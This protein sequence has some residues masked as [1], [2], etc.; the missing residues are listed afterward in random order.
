M[1]KILLILILFFTLHSNVILFAGFGNS[2]KVGNFFQYTID[3]FPF[4]D[5]YAN[6]E[7]ISDTTLNNGITYS[8]IKKYYIGG[9]NY[10]Y[11]EYID[12]VTN[13]WYVYDPTCLSADTNGNFLK[14][15]LNSDSGDIWNGCGYDILV[16]N[17]GMIGN[18][19][20]KQNL[21][22]VTL[23]AYPIITDGQFDTYID[24][25]GYKGTNGYNFQSELTGAI[26]DGV[27]Y[28]NIV[29]INQISTQVPEKFNLYNNYPNPF[30]PTTRIKFEIPKNVKVSLKVFDILGRE[31][32][33]LVNSELN[34]GVYEYTFE[35]ARLSSGIYFYTLKTD[36]F[37]ET[38]KMLLVK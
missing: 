34:A 3:N 30:N 22:F 33:S 4:E 28:G 23:T 7:I 17:K 14:A 32:A 27:T 31:V 13:K 21:E 6:W 19:L 10:Y 35:G 16:Y 18:F 26:I 20:G 9:A 36:D 24:F 11:L 8:V 1:K 5:Y 15:D 29:S 12:T 25:F 38:K 2:L 37:I